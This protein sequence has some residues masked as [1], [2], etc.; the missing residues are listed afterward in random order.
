MLTLF[1]QNSTTMEIRQCLE[2]AQK[3]SGRKDQKF[4]A[5]NCSAIPENLFESELF[6]HEKGSFTG[7]DQR[8][9]GKFQYAEGGTLF[10]D[11][12]G[13]HGGHASYWGRQEERTGK[14][15]LKQGWPLSLVPA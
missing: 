4:V 2:C 9:I 6:G 14:P 8:K 3:L 13:A 7:A 5:N 11:E 1:F 10:L 15:R 12:I